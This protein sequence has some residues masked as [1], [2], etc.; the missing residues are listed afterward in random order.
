MSFQT[1]A[2][3]AGGKATSQFN[4][5]LMSEA[6]KRKF[7]DNAVR[8]SMEIFRQQ[9]ATPREAAIKALRGSPDAL[10]SNG[11]RGWRVAEELEARTG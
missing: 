4:E 10:L 3:S 9:G 1:L 2:T 7:A 11:M 5:S 8:R 6:Q